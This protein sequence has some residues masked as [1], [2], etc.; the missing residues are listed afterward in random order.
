L[1]IPAETLKPG[2]VILPPAREIQLWMR[3]DALQRGLSE[4]ALHLTVVDV[5]EGKPDKKGRWII[6]RCDQSAEWLAGRVG[7]PFTFRARPETPW[8]IIR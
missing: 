3:R 6:V 1:N 4:T 5:R 8:P 7:Y 2:D